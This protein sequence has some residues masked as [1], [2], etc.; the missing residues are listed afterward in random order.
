MLLRHLRP[1]H[2]IALQ[3]RL[4]DQGGGKVPLRALEGAARRGQIQGL[5]FPALLVQLPH[6]RGDLVLVALF[7]AEYRAENGAAALG[8]EIAGP[9][10]EAAGLRRGFQQ[11]LLGQE[12]ID[13]A[14]HHVFQLPT[15]GAGVHQQS[16]AHRAGDAGGKFQALQPVLLG[17]A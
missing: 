10:A 12:V 7:R 15:V 2:G 1:A 11:G 4:L 5:L 16:A 8:F 6:F 3:A 17:K 13:H 14:L 9:V